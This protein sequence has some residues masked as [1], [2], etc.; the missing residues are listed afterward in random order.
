M[1]L[2]L[3][4]TLTA[5]KKPLFDGWSWEDH[6]CGIVIQYSS[7]QLTFESDA[8]L[9]IPGLATVC[10]HQ[11]GSRYLAGLWERDI[12]HGML[13]DCGDEL[14]VMRPRAHLAPTW[15]WACMRREVAWIRDQRS[16]TRYHVE[17][18]DAS[19]EPL[20]DVQPLGA[21]KPGAYLDIRGPCLVGLLASRYTAQDTTRFPVFLGEH[22]YRFNVDC[23]PEL[24]EIAGSE[25]VRL[26]WCTE[27]INATIG[28]GRDRL[29]V[30]RAIDKTL[31]SFTR[32]G[33]IDSAGPEKN[34]RDLVAERTVRI[35]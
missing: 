16:L 17:L 15:S 35:L 30:L 14:E 5:G 33:I 21:V 2:W 28:S 23:V 32:V 8:M 13:W 27:E 22:E 19:V 29:L 12:L 11:N 6:W 1:P 31:G 26:W 3:C 10:G 7:R 25:V 9:A 34:W 20:V 4:S 18:V 24:K